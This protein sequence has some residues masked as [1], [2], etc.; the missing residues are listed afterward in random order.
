MA[1][2]ICYNEIQSSNQV[3]NNNEKLDICK[4]CLLSMKEQKLKF[5]HTFIIEDCLKSIRRMLEKG[6]PIVI[7]DNY[8]DLY[9]ID[10][11]ELNNLY[12]GYMKEQILECNKKLKDIAN[13]DE[14]DIKEKALEIFK[15]FNQIILS[16]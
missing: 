4:E 11:N 10:K 5:V 14:I 12:S 9:D 2:S 6:I 8:T 3:Y 13:K 7:L 1:C 16:T 15:K